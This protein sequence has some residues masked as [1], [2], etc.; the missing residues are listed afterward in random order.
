MIQWDPGIPILCSF[1]TFFH[2]FEVKEV[3]V[4]CDPSYR[5]VFEGLPPPLA[6]I[7]FANHVLPLGY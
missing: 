1:H 2:M 3:I 7:S 4:V 6:L 5:D